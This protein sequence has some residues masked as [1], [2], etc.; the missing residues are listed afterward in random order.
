MTLWWPGALGFACATLQLMHWTDDL[1]CAFQHLRQHHHHRDPP[2]S[3]SA[4]PRC[5]PSVLPV[6]D[7]PRNR[8]RA[9]APT[10]ILSRP[11]CSPPRVNAVAQPN[12]GRCRSTPASWALTMAAQTVDVRVLSP[13]P[14]ADGG[15]TFA[16]L[17]T[18]TSIGEL[19]LKIRDTLPSHPAPERMRIIYLGRVVMN[20]TTL[21]VVLGD[22]RFLN[23]NA[24]P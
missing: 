2:P 24:T 21:G 7:L 20:E 6:P 23:Y 15:I 18:S 16:A 19:K 11:S 17:P 14:E 10:P 22:V 13:S 1:R 8:I 9:R 12:A 4:R 5:R 3:P